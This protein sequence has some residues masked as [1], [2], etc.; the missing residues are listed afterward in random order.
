MLYPFADFFLGANSPEGFRSLFSDSFDPADG[1]RVFILKGGPGTGKS[2]LMKSIA[3]AARQKGLFTERAFCSSDPDSLD[4]VI[5]PNEK[6][7]I[8]DGTAPHV[9]EPSFPGA[10]ESIVNLGEAFDT[11]LLSKRTDDI[12]SVSK[13]C[14]ECHA[15]AVRFLKCAQVFDDNT[16]LLVS[17]AIDEEKLAR[18]AEGL[19]SDYISHSGGGKER[20]RLL[21]AVTKNGVSFFD[22]TVTAMCDTIIPIE[23]RYG[24]VSD[25]LL[26][27]MR[28]RLRELGHEFI[29]CRCSQ[30]GRIEHIILPAERTA[31]TTVNSYHACPSD[32]R[33]THAERF[34]DSSVISENAKKI[35]CNKKAAA[36]FRLLASREMLRAK[37]VHDELEQIYSAAVDF[38]T[39]DELAR[40]TATRFF[41]YL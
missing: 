1:W 18:R 3:S 8:F 39:V 16:S 13:R 19:L 9:L 41:D 36:E 38:E 11:E 5:L 23:D 40:I 6:R 28:R 34:L 12:I 25:R 22:G 33:A 35:S 2:T 29:C 4:A 37:A 10:C 20:T 17:P 21:S 32:A 7:A 27:M 14:G 30:S 31:F 15:A 24:C 26:G